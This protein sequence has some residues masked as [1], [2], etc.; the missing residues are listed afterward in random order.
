MLGFRQWLQR[1]FAVALCLTWGRWGTIVPYSKPLKMEIGKPI[2]VAMK[3]KED[4]TQE[5]IDLLHA[6]FIV[7]QVPK[8]V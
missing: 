7:A 5:D 8:T 6:K 3:K 4:I 2:P 1:T